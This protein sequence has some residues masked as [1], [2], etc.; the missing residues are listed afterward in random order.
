MANFIKLFEISNKQYKKISKQL[1]ENINKQRKQIKETYLKIQ[2][3]LLCR[4]FIKTYSQ[5]E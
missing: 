1:Y 5:I 2:T 3:S 4:L